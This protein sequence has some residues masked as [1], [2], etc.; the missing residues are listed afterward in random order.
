MFLIICLLLTLL[1][2]GLLSPAQAAG[3]DLEVYLGGARIGN[4]SHG[5]QNAVINFGLDTPGFD[6][7]DHGD[8]TANY[9]DGDI[10][11]HEGDRSTMTI[12]VKNNPLLKELASSGHARL[13]FGW[14]RLV[15]V[16]EDGSWGGIEKN[17]Q[18]TSGK[19]FIYQEGGMY[20]PFLPDLSDSTDTSSTGAKSGSASLEEDTIIRIEISGFG[21]DT[22]GPSGVRGLYVRFKDTTRPILTG[23]SFTGDGAERENPNTGQT[24]LYVKESEYIDLIYKFSESV[25]PNAIVPD[26]SD[27]FLRHPLFVNPDGEGLPASGQQQ[28][29][30]N[31]TYTS[32]TLKTLHNRIS[33]RYT[34]VKYHHSGNLPLMPMMTGS[35]GALNPMNLTMQ[36]KLDQAVLADAAGNVATIH[37]THKADS[38]SNSFLRGKAANPF[39]YENDGYR[40]IVDAV[41]PKYTKTGNGIQPEMLT[42]V[43]LNGH[44]TITFSLQFTEEVVVKRGWDLART[45]LLF[46]NGMRAYYASGEGTKTW[47]FS[48][49]LDDAES[50]ETPLLKVL[51][52]T[53]ENKGTDTL[54]LQ[55][56]AGNL[57]LQPANYDG[58]HIDGDESM[59]QS[60]IDW[61]DLSI[62][63]TPPIISFRFEEGG[64]SA[65][66]YSQNGK[67]T[68]EAD[69]PSLL[70]PP[71]DPVNPETQRPSKGIYRPSNMTGEASPS[72]GLVYY[73]WSQNPG[74]PL[75]GKEDDHYAAIKRYSLAAKQPREDLYQGELVDMNLSVVNNK[76]NM[77]APPSESRMPENSGV[78]YLHAWTADMTWDSARELMQYE[79]MRSFI[80][81]NKTQYEAWKA[82]LPEEASEQDR[83][84]HAETKALAAVGQYGDLSVWELENFKQDDSNWNYAVTPFLLDNRHPEIVFEGIQDDGT[85][86]VKAS[87]AVTDPHSGVAEAYY[88]FAPQGVEPDEESWVSLDL[89]GGRAVVSTLNGVFEDGAYTLS[90]K[91]VDH[92]GNEVMSAMEGPLTVDSAST[93]RASFFPD[94]NPEYTQAHAIEFHISGISLLNDEI[95]YAVTASGARPTNANEYTKLTG[96]TV[97]ENVYGDELS[98]TI[99]ADSTKNGLQY[100]HVVAEPE[101]QSRVYTYVKTYYFDN[102]APEVVF[103]RNGSL[104]PSEIQE[105]S[106]AVT[107]PYSANGLITKYQWVLEGETP[108]DASSGNWLDLPADGRMILTNEALAP[109]VTADY[110]L[111][112]HAID[113]AGNAVIAATEPFRLSKLSPE[114]PPSSGQSDL[115]YVY[116]S[117]EGAYTAI[118]K[119]G[120]DAVDK[121]GYE[122][123]LSPD[124]GNRWSAWK[125]YS[126]F[127][128]VKVPTDD[129]DQLKIQAKFRTGGGEAGAPIPLQADG[130]SDVEPVYAVVSPHTT[131]DVQSATGLD[132]LITPGLAVRVTPAADNPAMP[133]RL[134]QSN[135]FKVRANGFYSFLLTDVTDESRTDMLYVV[136]SNIDD[137]PP[138]GEAI[139]LGTMPT[140]QSI[141]ARL[142]HTSEDV[143]ILNNEGRSVYTFAENGS[144]TFE[145]ADEAGNV[146]T[147]TATV[148]T[149]D[150][151]APRVRIVQSYQYG[152][153]AED[154][155]G[156]ILGE[157]GNVA[158]ASGVVLSL[159]KASPDAKDFFVPGGSATAVLRENGEAS[160]IVSDRFGNTT[161]ITETVTH[162]ASKP[163]E[164]EEVEYSFVDHN[165]QPI[166][167]NE[168][169]EIDGRKYAKGKVQLTITG[170]T[171]P[172]NTVF[173]GM[174]PVALPEGGY[175]NAISAGDGTF[176]LER[177]YTRNGPATIAL[178]DLLGNRNKYKLTIEGL[179]NTAPEIELNRSVTAIKQG[180]EDFDFRTDLGGFTVR[181]NVSKPEHILVEM[182]EL[183]LAT[184]GEKEVVY[185]VTDEVGNQT[186]LK[187]KVFVTS[188]E[189]MLIFANGQLISS[190]VGKSPL[191]ET[192]RLTFDVEGY[193]TM[194][195]DGMELTNEV[196][197]FDLLYYSGLYREGQMK[198]IAKE[199]SYAELLDGNF[200]VTFPQAG[201]YTIIVRNQERERE[202]FTFF[203][204]KTQ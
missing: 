13:E 148:T 124:G 78:W 153:D 191:F 161:R 175:G 1:P 94:M 82:E 102:E 157:D 188:D 7:D 117:G 39:D 91:S 128:S 8:V 170:R 195:V 36:E 97:T 141:S 134:G 110:R 118:I 16:E 43:V 62:D 35:S 139:L 185:T 24:E 146:G 92:A 79:K 48:I 5:A 186:T 15:T 51:A 105:V 132:L 64:A 202:Y 168:L 73:Y 167:D 129:P 158:A 63:N 150:K 55:D 23:Y 80:E 111:Y 190:I 85:S 29:L 115:I 26:F 89:T 116:Y 81:E 176:R 90:V 120:L 68:I 197:T 112:V 130:I 193:N 149:I 34:G 19:I 169:V 119:L 59:L 18:K 106:A 187:Q 88:Q 66:Q 154:V 21:E 113:G 155:F 77:L 40:I 100:V 28:Y 172:G 183:D 61:A 160:F 45:Y 151:E 152:E 6:S 27:H 75:A 140:N 107:E 9:G 10:Y 184:T 86:E 25:R 54:V 174:L 58:I 74:D 194:L 95:A 17:H 196:G 126:N 133:E 182:S 41:P 142:I 33:Y 137:T 201:W 164:P 178:S 179:D 22:N 32:S 166:P 159:E 181:D 44:D 121:R 198:Y 173:E 136:V 52:L 20:N 30:R 46:S 2:A 156:T 104:Y 162:I 125:S 101:D 50:L 177:T 3:D 56:Y 165:G 103:N 98:F 72:V 12:R 65:D 47:T 131:K 123:S 70:V 200:S 69:D 67:A 122:Y 109:G 144:F 60:K 14:S 96:T 143:R 49:E 163:P 189:G 71:L 171:V 57:L 135:T 42:G 4:A 180:K 37:M 147:A 127:V 203:I 83:E 114:S 76:T 138:T 84:F 11:L 31:T 99:P 38:G 93:V 87:I 204:A 199:I 192:N 145:F 53:H 108:P